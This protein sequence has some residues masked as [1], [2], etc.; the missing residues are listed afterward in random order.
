MNT[1]KNHAIP[2]GLNLGN[3]G[4]EYEISMVF[5]PS[6]AS[7]F[8]SARALRREEMLIS[9]FSHIFHPSQQCHTIPKKRCIAF[10]LGQSTLRSAGSRRG[11]S[12]AAIT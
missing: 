10:R 6:R 7:Y 2:I 12:A 1:K 3:I 9:R 5:C 4:I 11:G 8:F